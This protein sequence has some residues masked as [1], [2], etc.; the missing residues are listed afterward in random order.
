[1]PSSV[2]SFH[3]TDAELL[4]GMLV[5][6]V[7]ACLADPGQFVIIDAP[8]NR[9][10]QALVDP[11]GAL[12]V[13]TVSRAFLSGSPDPLTDADEQELRR[14]GW[15]PPGEHSPNWHRVFVEPWPW[16]AP[17]A[18]EL[19]GRTLLGVHHAYG[20]VMTIS[21]HPASSKAPVRACTAAC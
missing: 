20:S 5:E 7:D 1:M 16:P 14:L 6:A 11:E 13:E 15:R 9:Y 3:V 18:A 8:E 12:Q 17:L 2:A 21:A 19:T 10:V 4:F